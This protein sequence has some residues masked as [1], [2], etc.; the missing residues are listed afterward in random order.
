[1]NRLDA[2]RSLS[3]RRRRLIVLTAVLTVL[4]T[5]GIRVDSFKRNASIFDRIPSAP[6]K[7]ITVAD[8]R[9]TTVVASR[10]VP[11][12]TCLVR[13]IVA[14]TLCHRYGHD[15]DLYVGVNRESE[16]FAAHSWVESH[17]E[18]VVGDDVN[19]GRYEVLGVVAS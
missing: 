7:G 3:P 18:I 12:T 1:M 8:I 16:S 6:E 11:G 2:F 10:Y 13:G 4:S 5:V 15:A 9:W 17:G 14:H 19:L